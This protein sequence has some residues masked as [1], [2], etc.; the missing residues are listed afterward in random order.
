M[1]QTVKL[2][3]SATQGAVPTT[4]QLSLG[5]IAIN[6]YDGK[7]YFKQDNGTE[8]V[9]TLRQINST[10]DVSEGSN[11]YYTDAR[12]RAAVG[13]VTKDMTGFADRTASSLSFNSGTRLLVLTPTNNITLYYQGT[14]YIF[15]TPKSV[16][17]T[18]TS[19]GRYI[20]FDPS[21]QSLVEMGIGAYPD[22]KTDL[23]V[24]YVYWD[25]PNATAIIFG[26]ERHGSDRDTQ[27]H[28]SKH[29]EQGAVWRSGGALSYTLNSEST[30]SVGVASPVV[31]ADEDLVHTITHATTPSNPYEQILETSANL[32]V[33]YLSGTSYI[34]TA[35]STTPWVRATTAY[36]NQV[37]G[38]SGSLVAAANNAYITYWMVATNDSVYP[39]KLIMG[40]YAHNQ[41][42]DAEA[43]TFE[44]YGLPVPEL[45]P[46]YKIILQTNSNYT[47]KV[48]LV[49]VNSLL[50]PQTTISGSFSASNH[51]SLAGR[52]SLDQHPISAISGLQDAL[53]AKLTTT[54]L[55]TSITAID[56]PTSGIDADLLDGQHGSYYTNY[57][58]LSNTPTALSDF[59]NDLWEVTSTVPTDGT[60]KPAGY[61]W[62]II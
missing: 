22:F 4:A 41:L 62:Y 48:I 44:G 59:S 3:R 45:A 35:P 27:W 55:L 20:K 28:L 8:S 57:N 26:D 29:L 11:L 10:S 33:I 5:E 51:D 14:S 31:V 47:N 1:A 7:V 42:V 38:G 16:T 61:V 50:N 17:I 32:P 19:G 18:D 58:N 53:N 49:E 46:M 54:N 56:G 37:S 6:T 23:L 13:A 2:R 52:A 36:Y 24:A 12:A 9:L 25:S 34:Q 15:S 21:T 30:I 60:G 43:E 40:R 39:I